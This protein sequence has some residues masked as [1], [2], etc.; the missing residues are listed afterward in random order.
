MNKKFNKNNSFQ[1]NKEYNNNKKKNTKFILK[2]V[3]IIKDPKRI[4]T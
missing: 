3:I 4:N 1:N 2:G